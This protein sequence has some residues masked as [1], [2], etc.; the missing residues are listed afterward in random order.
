MQ[1]SQ[2]LKTRK[3]SPSVGEEILDLDFSRPLDDATAGELVRLLGERGMIFARNQQLTP[4]LQID[5]AQKFGVIHV[6]PYFSPIDGFPQVAE[7]RKEPDQAFNIG[8]A[9]HTDNSYDVA[10]ALGSLLYAK[11]IPPVGGDTLWISMY[12]AYDSLSDGMKE[13]LSKL[14]ALHT[15]QKTFGEGGSTGRKKLAGI[16][17]DNPNVRE[18]THPVVITHPISGRKALFVNESFTSHFTGWTPEESAPL[19]NFLYQHA[20]K[21]D[22]Q[23]RL[24]WKAGTFALWDNRCTWHFAINDYHG[25]RRVMHR[26]QIAGEVLH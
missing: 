9:W 13:T 6:N 7:V 17:S 18:A 21:P 22:Y 3:L 10:P 24:Q 20:R 19:L 11:E 16:R 23:C 4:K 14:T 5:L 12:D 25:F 26:V 1:S 15:T 8:E 2:R